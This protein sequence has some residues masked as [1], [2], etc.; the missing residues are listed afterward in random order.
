MG[1][2]TLSVSP[3]FSTSPLAANFA[4]SLNV[5]GIFMLRSLELGPVQNWVRY[6]FPESHVWPRR[7]RGQDGADTL[8]KSATN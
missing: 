4:R 7:F 2:H 6:Y 8:G 1:R 3:S 5:R